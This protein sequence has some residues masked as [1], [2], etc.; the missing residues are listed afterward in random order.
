MIG[1][2]TAEHS[3][4]ILTYHSVGN[5]DHPMNVSVPAFRDQIQWL[6]EN[7]PC[8]T[9]EQALDGQ[10][11]IAVT[12]DDGYRDNLINAQ[13][14]LEQ[15]H[16]PWTLFFVAGR[17]GGVLDHDR[18]RQD[19]TLLTWDEVRALQRSGVAV[20]G[21]TLTHPRLS[22]LSADDQRREIEECYREI[23][24][25]VGNAPSGFAYPFGS[26]LDYTPATVDLVKQAGFGYAVSNR[27][28]PL[29]PGDKW[30]ARRIWIDRTDTLEFFQAKVDGR[31]DRLRVLDSAAGIRARR[32]AAPA[33]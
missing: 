28:G 32:L 10:P 14:V 16:V 19:A 4:R 18:S 23:E 15:H 5:R 30:T 20:G 13:P 11:G 33:G 2:A 6:A 8:I 3:S 9:V 1:R 12:F 27:Y 29:E 31:L 26:A 7:T 22:A 24:R 21:H 17:A 25:E